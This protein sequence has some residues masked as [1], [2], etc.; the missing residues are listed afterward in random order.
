MAGA[1]CGSGLLGLW[2]SWGDTGS[3][4]YEGSGPLRLSVLS[5]ATQPT[6]SLGGE[7]RG[8]L[9]SAPLALLPAAQRQTSLVLSVV[10]TEHH[11]LKYSV[12]Q[13]QL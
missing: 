5:S 8:E 7:E 6:P 2:H 13:Q 12:F 4:G 9:L 3:S 10:S 1:G 11:L